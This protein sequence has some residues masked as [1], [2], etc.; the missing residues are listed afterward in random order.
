MIKYIKKTKDILLFQIQR[1]HKTVG[2]LPVSWI[3]APTF[4]LEYDKDFFCDAL[5]KMA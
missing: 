2:E 5:I 1:K 3:K 4:S